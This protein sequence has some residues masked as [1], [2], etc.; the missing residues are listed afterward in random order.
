[1]QAFLLKLALAILEDPKF[2]AAVENILGKLIT[3]RILP[4]VPIAVGAAVK[5]AVDEVV[6]KVPGINAVVDVVSTTESAIGALTNL[7]PGIVLPVL[8]D[9]ENFWKPKP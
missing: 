7:I 9:I 2:Q 4:L 6:D 3:E 1:M 5:S 8:G